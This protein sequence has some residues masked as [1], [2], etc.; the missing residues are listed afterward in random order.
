MLSSFYIY[1]FFC[2]FLMAFTVTI[3]VVYEIQS[4]CLNSSI[5]CVLSFG[6]SFLE[7]TYNFKNNCTIRNAVQFLK[8]TDP[9]G[10]PWRK[11]NRE[12]EC[13]CRWAQNK[14]PAGFVSSRVVG[15][16]QES[17]PCSFWFYNCELCY[18]LDAMCI[19]GYKKRKT[20]TITWKSPWTWPG[21]AVYSKSFD[22]FDIHV[23]TKLG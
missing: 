13:S 12:A 19:E 20:K 8:G 5:S 17:F 1:F 22:V 18:P 21:G 6:C 7:L 4:I 23:I 15:G 14:E 16:T 10:I 3:F 9:G 11:R 2:Q